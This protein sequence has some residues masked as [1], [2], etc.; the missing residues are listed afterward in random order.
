[1]EQREENEACFDYPESRQRKTR[2]RRKAKG[3]SEFF[4]NFP[5][6]IEIFFVGLKKAT[7]P[8]TWL[9]AFEALKQIIKD[10]ELP[11]KIIFIDELPWMDT[12]RSGFVSGG[13]PYYW[14]KLERGL[15]LAQN[16]DNLFFNPDGE[17][18]DEFDAL[19]A[20]LFKNPDPYITVVQ[21]L[22]TKRT[23]L[24]RE[25]LIA[26]AGLEDIT[27]GAAELLSEYACSTST[28]Y[29]GPSASSVPSA[30]SARGTCPRKPIVV[31]H[32]L[33]SSSIATIPSSTSAK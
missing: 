10:S 9:D 25:E 30:V 3:Q 1:M 21:T 7:L 8:H 13:I 19:Y 4:C 18:Y 12:Q 6:S 28:R 26:Q 20:S 31:V 5:L 33:T 11:K 27:T 32:R 16:I 22:G 2:S 14:S 23:G 15:S 29:A 24:T 17:L